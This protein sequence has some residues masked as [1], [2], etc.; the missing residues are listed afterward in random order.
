M[1]AKELTDLR[2]EVEK[3]LPAA[4]LGREAK[5]LRVSKM[6]QLGLQ[7]SAS[8]IADLLAEALVDL[9]LKTPGENAIVTAIA[10]AFRDYAVAFGHRPRALALGAALE[11]VL[12]LALVDAMMEQAAEDGEMFDDEEED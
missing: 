9:D 2:N 5:R 12:D 7:R 3:S 1:E 6:R 4:R 8:D 10:R 11:D